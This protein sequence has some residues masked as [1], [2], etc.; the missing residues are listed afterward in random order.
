MYYL[1]IKDLS[2][3]RAWIEKARSLD[4]QN[5][6]AYLLEAQILIS[7]GNTVESRGVLEKVL[8]THPNLQQ[9]VDL[10]NKIR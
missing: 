2:K 5:P 8:Q 4:P 6:S 1:Q 3:G 9:A 10:L 7:L